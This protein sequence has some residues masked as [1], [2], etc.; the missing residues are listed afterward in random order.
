MDP[1]LR[2]DLKNGSSSSQKSPILVK[3]EFIAN[4]GEDLVVGEKILME[5]QLD[6]ESMPI[7][8]EIQLVK[9]SSMPQFKELL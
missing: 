1:T 5:E 4:K 7:K 6:K 8:E 9:V 3:E 2:K